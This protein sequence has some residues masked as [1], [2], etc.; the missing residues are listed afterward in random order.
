MNFRRITAEIQAWID[1]I[2]AIFDRRSVNIGHVAAIGPAKNSSRGEN[3]SWRLVPAEHEVHAADKMNEQIA[4]DAGAV[5]FPATPARKNIRIE[6]ALG[7][8]ALPS[9][10]VNGRGAGVSW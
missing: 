6:R 9:V 1:G 3:A 8:R 10:P 2:L 7:H 4:G 5:F